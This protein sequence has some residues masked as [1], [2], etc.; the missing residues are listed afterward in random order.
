V[1]A[2]ILHILL[3]RTAQKWSK[4]NQGRVLHQQTV[5]SKEAVTLLAKNEELDVLFIRYCM[6]HSDRQ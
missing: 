6:E 2:D 1:G 3:P 5:L 4:S